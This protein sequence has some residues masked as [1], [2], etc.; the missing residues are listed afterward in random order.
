MDSLS[1]LPETPG[2]KTQEEEVIMSQFFGDQQNRSNQQGYPPQGQPNQGSNQGPPQGYPP[3]GYPNQGQHNQGPP[4]GYPPQGQ[5]NPNQGPPPGY[6]RRDT[7]FPPSETYAQD[8]QPQEKGCGTWKIVGIAILLFAVMANSYTGSAL[9][10]L[11]KLSESNMLSFS[12]QVV[13][14]AIFLAIATY[15]LTK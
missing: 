10:K 7:S 14:F 12:V 6:P 1:S 5:P 3:Q 4:Q 9:S 15:F 11:P 13:L 2:Q 8:Q